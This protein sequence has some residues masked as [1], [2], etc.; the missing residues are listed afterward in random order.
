LTRAI[1]ILNL[2]AFPQLFIVVFVIFPRLG[3]GRFLPNRFQFTSH[4]AVLLPIVFVEVTLLLIVSQSV[5][6]GIEHPCVTCDQMLL[7]VLM[8]L[9]EIYG[10]VPVRR[11]L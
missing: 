8:L 7:P 2:P 10:L 1:V 9:S 11:P 5:S 4:P 6:L 3:Q